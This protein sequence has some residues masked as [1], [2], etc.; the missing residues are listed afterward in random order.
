MG[1]QVKHKFKSGIKVLV[2]SRQLTARSN[3]SNFSSVLTDKLMACLG[4][5]DL[6][7]L[8][9]V[10]PFEITLKGPF[11]MI[12]DLRLTLSVMRKLDFSLSV[13]LCEMLTA[14]SPES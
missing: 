14:L 1:V 10:F 3:G 12:S 6:G 13:S 8:F 11:S 4:C 7:R 5:T 2:E 9:E